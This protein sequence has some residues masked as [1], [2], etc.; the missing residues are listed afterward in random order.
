MVSHRESSGGAGRSTCLASL[1]SQKRVWN[2]LPLHHCISLFS[3]ASGKSQ[4]LR[5]HP[6][7]RLVHDD[8]AVTKYLKKM[9]GAIGNCG[10]K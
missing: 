6:R 5:K 10:R 2:N 3:S 7:V 4:S 8:G 1:G 9:K